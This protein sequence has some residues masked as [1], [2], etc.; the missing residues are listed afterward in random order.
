M[1]D[2]L[3]LSFLPLHDGHR[4]DSNAV[5]PEFDRTLDSGHVSGGYGISDFIP[6]QC[7]GS[8]YGVS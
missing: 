5:N 2:D 8:F 6:I 1:I 3:R 7:P 4:S